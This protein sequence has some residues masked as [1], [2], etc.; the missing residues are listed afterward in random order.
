VDHSSKYLRAE[1]YMLPVLALDEGSA[2]LKILHSN[3]W[4]RRSQ[5]VSIHSGFGYFV[6]H[7]QGKK[8]KRRA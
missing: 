1:V 3:K 6:L 7:L 2:D 5:S 8:N 4:L